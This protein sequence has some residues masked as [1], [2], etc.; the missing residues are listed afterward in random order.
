MKYRYTN[1][2][3]PVNELTNLVYNHFG[4]NPMGWTK[5]DKLTEY[6]HDKQF[7]NLIFDMWSFLEKNPTVILPINSGQ[8]YKIIYKFQLATKSLDY[9][10]LQIEKCY[11]FLANYAIE[12]YN[13][14]YKNAVSKIKKI[15]FRKIKDIEEQHKLNFFS[16]L[17][18][19]FSETLFCDEHTISEEIISPLNFWEDELVIY[20][21]FINLSSEN[22]YNN[23]SECPYKSISIFYKYDKSTP[24]PSTDIVGNLLVHSNISSN[25]NGYF[26]EI[27]DKNDNASQIN[28]LAQLDEIIEYFTNT[29]VSIINQFKVMSQIERLK[30]KIQCEYYALR[31]Y[32]EIIGREWKPILSN[33]NIDN[34]TSST[35]PIVSA[36]LKL[37]E[38]SDEREFFELLYE[39]N[40]PLVHW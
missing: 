27:I 16:A 35:R 21:N 36:N 9:S 39:I 6:A 11:L 25:L 34:I 33:L 40:N 7:V 13:Q 3:Q 1:V 23:I 29:M 32:C 30:K 17:M 14:S 24:K 4:K 2:S 38:I 5:I 19:G 22:L 15:Q 28:T 10:T 18:R 37:G 26:I 12:I 31:P 20:R 8:I